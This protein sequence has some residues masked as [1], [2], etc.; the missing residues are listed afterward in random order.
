MYGGGGVSKEFV[1]FTTHGAQFQNESKVCCIHAASKGLLPCS[2]MRFMST[3]A[4]LLAVLDPCPVIGS[5]RTTTS[6]IPK[7][8][9]PEGSLQTGLRTVG[10]NLPASVPISSV[11]SISQ[12]R[13]ASQGRN[14]CRISLLRRRCCDGFLTSPQQ[15][16]GPPGTPSNTMI[17]QG[18]VVVRAGNTKYSP[19]P[20]IRLNAT[21]VKGLRGTMPLT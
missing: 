12:H 2:T 5:L 11:S 14:F 20:G 17:S 13:S 18:P 7:T 10:A 16:I 8:T 4:A 6:A 9:R 21:A 1:H 15:S 19:T 3:F